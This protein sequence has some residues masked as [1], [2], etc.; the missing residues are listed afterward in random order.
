MS[1]K[2]YYN[3]GDLDYLKVC[4]LVEWLKVSASSFTLDSIV[5]LSVQPSKII[6][7]NLDTI[8]IQLTTINQENLWVKLLLKT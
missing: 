8:E 3:Y 4:L 5:P 1:Y 6:R 7:I 2:L